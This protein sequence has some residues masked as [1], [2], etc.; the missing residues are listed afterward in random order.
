MNA[1][2][3]FRWLHCLLRFHRMVTTHSGEG[4]PVYIGCECGKCWYGSGYS[5]DWLRFAEA[6]KNSRS[7]SSTEG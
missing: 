6:C 7:D 5:E 1:A 2:Y 4:K 3:F